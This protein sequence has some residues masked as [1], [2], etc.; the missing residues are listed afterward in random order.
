[1]AKKKEAET[2]N[3]ETKT[4]ENEKIK[5]S[6][7][8]AKMKSLKKEADGTGKMIY[9]GASVPGMKANTVFTG[10]IPEI[11]DVPFVRDLCIPIDDYTE[12][13]KR[14]AVTGSYEAVCYRQS[15]KYASEL[16]TNK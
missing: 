6:Q 14:K 7:A 10:K 9:A 13:L 5:E 15:V 12:F 11:L 1:M 16:K 8:I 2:E 4:A 3:T